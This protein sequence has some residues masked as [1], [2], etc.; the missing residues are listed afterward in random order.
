MPVA[1]Q[2]FTKRLQTQSIILRQ[3]NLSQLKRRRGDVTVIH[4]LTVST[5]RST[6]EKFLDLYGS[7]LR[8]SN[9]EGWNYSKCV[10]GEET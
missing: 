3:G 6:P 4:F 8:L 9:S 10:T 2:D 7:E 1:K 5:F